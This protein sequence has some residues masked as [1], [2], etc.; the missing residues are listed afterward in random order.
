MKTFQRPDFSLHFIQENKTFS[1]LSL[2]DVL[3]L[4]SAVAP[5]QRKNI[6]I[7]QPSQSDWLRVPDHSIVAHS[8][9][10]FQRNIKAPV[11]DFASFELATPEIMQKEIPSVEAHFSKNTPPPPKAT[12]NVEPKVEAAQRSDSAIQT[13]TIQNLAPSDSK[14]APPAANVVRFDPPLLQVDR[15]MPLKMDIVSAMIVTIDNS[16]FTVSCCLE[17]PRSFKLLRLVGGKDFSTLDSFLRAKI[18]GSKKA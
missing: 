15:D 17:T 5:A 6:L 14:T 11:A 10:K 18:A 9:F 2:N 8:P 16:K 13:F 1:H 7:Y 12:K 3:L 4:L